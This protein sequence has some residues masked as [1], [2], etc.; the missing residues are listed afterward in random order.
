MTEHRYECEG[1]VIKPYMPRLRLSVMEDE[2]N[3]H[4]QTERGDMIR[5][6]SINISFPL[7]ISHTLQI[8][9][10]DWIC[11][12][13]GNRLYIPFYIQFLF[14]IIYYIS[15]WINNDGNELKCRDNR[16]LFISH[17]IIIYYFWEFVSS[18]TSTEGC[19]CH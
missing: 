12:F 1:G 14:V 16:I 10:F 6:L 15:I 7:I 11:C 9:L 18:W 3:V 17:Y 2:L 4:K 8:I 5:D 19:R 13:I